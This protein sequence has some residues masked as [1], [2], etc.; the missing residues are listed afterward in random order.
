M[1][2]ETLLKS[3][4]AKAPARAVVAAPP[5]K[6][7]RR[8]P[9]NIA[10]AA[11][12]LAAFGGYAFVSIFRDTHFGSTVDLA[13][14]SQTVWGY[15]QFQ[16]IP[17]TIVGVPNLLG[18]HFHP[19]L[20]ALAPFYWIWNSPEVL[21]LAQAVLLALA[22]IPIFLWGRERLNAM[23]GLAFMAA[24]YVYWGTLAGMEFDF[25]HVVF[26]VA[27]I[28][29]ALYAAV[30]RRNRLLWAAVAVAM[31]SREDVALT[32]A[33][34]GFYIVVV[35]RRYILGAVLMV[36]NVLWFGLLIGAIMPAL[37]GG[38]YRHWTYQGLGD[39]PVAAVKHIFTEPFDSLKL[40]FVPVAKTRV[41]IGSFGNWLFLPLLS[42]LTLVALPYFFERF[43]NDQPTLWTFH[44]QY[45]MLPAPILAMASIDTLARIKSRWRWRVSL[46]ARMPEAIAGLVLVTTVVA[47]FAIL[48]PLDDLTKTVSPA[49]AAA[50]QSCLDVIPSSAAIAASQELLP[51][52][53]NRRQIYGIPTE[54]GHHVYVNPTTLGVEYIAI[55]LVSG[56]SPDVAMRDAVRTALAADYGIVCTKQLT[57]VLHRGA[58][59]KELS[60]Q[61]KHW[62]A[63]DCRAEGCLTEI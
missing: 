8:D 63:G 37:A 21:L 60:P 18:D 61:F 54:V 10:A 13:A 3:P 30:T 1:S 16:I 34:L 15:S 4:P 20:F 55:D 50:I 26:A 44:M 42:P 48:R 22:G 29:W 36:L 2:V 57:L 46:P 27:A 23:A 35:Q 52:L 5:L 58:T 19:V 38:P 9:A 25:H 14:Q 41:W 62:L 40:L 53:A 56:G 12:A 28:S 11:M 47:S 31:L 7:G 32:V 33:G 45:S 17:N 6:K 49:T 59:A 24:Y 39:G 51:H 43:W